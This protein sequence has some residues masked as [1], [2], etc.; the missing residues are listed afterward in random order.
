[1][2][3]DCYRDKVVLITGHTGFKGSWL[4]IWLLKLGARVVG[5]SL[6]PPTTPNLFDTC[7]LADHLQDLRGDIRDTAAMTRIICDVQPDFIF[8]LAAAPLVLRSY[9]D[10]VETFDVNV[11]G[12]LSVLQAVRQARQACSIVVVSTDKCYCNNEWDYGYRENDSLG[13]RDPYSA[14]KAAM[15]IA[16]A[17]FRDSFFPASQEHIHG[18]RLATVRAGNVIGGGD[19][20]PDRILPDAVRA[21]HAKE[22]L[23]VRSPQSIRPWQHVLEPLSGYLTLGARLPAPSGE[24]Y[25][26]GWNFGP[27]STD[28]FTVADLVETAARIWGSG[29]W[30][31]GNNPNAP[32]EAAVLRLCID[33]AATQLGWHPVWGFEEAVSRAVLWYANYFFQPNDTLESFDSCMGDIADYESAASTKGLA[34][35]LQTLGMAAKS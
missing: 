23:R 28:A 35:S 16:V 20:A 10:P 19:W 2:F 6:N 22:T 33:K 30:R 9:E 13:G 18:V 32:H 3:T 24:Q 1:V 27:P 12:T 31:I 8:H 21:F 17:S 26:G 15:E 7:G 34:W 29:C 14:S 11:I 4:A 5:Y 25:I